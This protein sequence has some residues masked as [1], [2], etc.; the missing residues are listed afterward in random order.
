VDIARKTND[1]SAYDK[2][3]EAVVRAY[4]RNKRAMRMQADYF[5]WSGDNISALDVANRMIELYPGDMSAYNYAATLAGSRY[6]EQ[7]GLKYLADAKQ[8][9]PDIPAPYRKLASYY[10][11]RG[12]L[13]SAETYWHEAYALDTTDE[14]TLLTEGVLFEAKGF[15]DSAVAVYKNIIVVDPFSAEAF[16]NLAWVMANNNLNPAQASN[17]AREAIGLSGGL[18]GDL[19]GTLGWSLFKEKKY[20]Q[21]AASMRTAIKYKPRDP[22]KRYMYGTILEAQDKKKEAVQQYQQAL[23]LGLQGAYRQDVEKA[24]ARLKK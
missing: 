1:T 9:N 14:A 5:L 18:N 2:A 23:D 19:H 7:Q 6:G 17:Y 3:V 15:P 24:I 21:A 22:F 12:Q 4:P 20:K 10:L 16:N 13:D 11:R 8:N